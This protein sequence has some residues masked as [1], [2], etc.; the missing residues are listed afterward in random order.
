M[1]KELPSRS[2]LCALQGGKRLSSRVFQ[3]PELHFPRAFRA[4]SADRG[5]E[6]WMRVE[7]GGLFRQAQDSL[8]MPFQ[9]RAETSSLFLG[10]RER[11]KE[12]KNGASK[13]AKLN[14]LAAKIKTKTINNSSII[15]VSLKQNNKALALALNAAKITAHRLTDDRMMLQK[16]VVL[17]HFKNACLRQKLTSV[18]KYIEELHQFMNSRLE[19]VMKLSRR[20]ENGPRSLFLADGRL[21]E[22]DDGQD[23]DNLPIRAAPMSMRIPLSHVDDKENTNDGGMAIHISTSLQTLPSNTTAPAFGRSQKSVPATALDTTSSSNPIEKLPSNEKNGQKLSKLDDIVSAF[24]LSTIFKDNS[25]S[26]LQ[27]S[28]SHSLFSLNNNSPVQQLKETTRPCSDNVL[29]SPQYVTKRKKHRTD[30]STASTNSNSDSPHDVSNNV[31]LDDQQWTKEMAPTSRENLE[32][33]QIGEL[34]TLKAKNKS[35]GKIKA[36]ETKALKKVST[37]TEKGDSSRQLECKL[38]NYNNEGMVTNAPNLFETKELDIIEMKAPKPTCHTGDSTPMAVLEELMPLN[39]SGQKKERGSQCFAKTT[40]RKTYVVGPAL[41]NSG[42]D[43]AKTTGTRTSFMTSPNLGD[44]SAKATDRRTYFVGLAP[45][46]SGHEFNPS[47]QEIKRGTFLKKVKNLERPLYLPES[48]SLHDKTQQDAKSHGCNVKRTF[49]CFDKSRGGRR[50]YVVDPAPQGHTIDCAPFPQDVKKTTHL[51]HLED[52]VSQFL[53]PG[54]PSL[55][56]KA[57]LDACSTQQSVCCQKEIPSKEQNV[58]LNVKCKKAEKMAQEMNTSLEL[59]ETGAQSLEGNTSQSRPR[60]RK[61][62]KDEIAEVS[63][64]NA[65]REHFEISI[66]GPDLSKIAPKVKKRKKKDLTGKSSQANTTPLLSVIGNPES[67]L[68]ASLDGKDTCLDRTCRKSTKIVQEVQISSAS[69]SLNKTNIS[70]GKMWW[71]VNSRVI[72]LKKL[73]DTK[74]KLNRKTCMVKDVFEDCTA[75]ELSPQSAEE[76]KTSQVDKAR[77]SFLHA[78]DTRTQQGSFLMDDV[79]TPPPAYGALCPSTSDISSAGHSKAVLSGSQSPANSFLQAAEDQVISETSDLLQILAGFKKNKAKQVASSRYKKK[80]EETPEMLLSNSALQ[81]NEIKVLEDVTNT[82]PDSCNSSSLAE[83]P[84]RPS[85]RKKKSVC[86]A[87]PRLNSKLRRGDPFTITDFLSSPVYKTKE[88][89]KSRKTKKI[90]KEKECS[91]DFIPVS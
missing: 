19:I 24:D 39:N 23:D 40:G 89:E 35:Y 1:R 20:S 73:E 71:D 51:K 38:D 14:A 80:R 60:K 50:A 30:L 72:G 48:S 68:P 66:D 44:D 78:S 59:P 12:K 16:E 46:N 7:L 18:N 62:K 69:H 2:Q 10:A 87:E 11:T 21:S 91:T 64:N 8:K 56:S 63:R 88:S 5:R 76:S 37:R 26:V 4:G 47:V 3:T 43:S 86:Y 36:N 53:S 31:L 90:M 29:M 75:S 22:A 70:S 82:C 6:R 28:R 33:S 17:C 13:T 84:A 42:N 9:E 58:A 74:P 34:V 61:T 25:T 77:W 52:L 49:Q 67:T 81:E 85:R 79:G 54:S 32:V 57:P 27:S 83:S 65:Q 15:K 45:T 41:P 55:S